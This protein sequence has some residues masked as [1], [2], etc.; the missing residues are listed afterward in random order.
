LFRRDLRV[1]SEI[2]QGWKV[3]EEFRSEEMGWGK[4][5]QVEREL[6]K[7]GGNGSGDEKNRQQKGLSK[8]LGQLR[9]RME[10]LAVARGESEEAIDDGN[11]EDEDEGEEDPMDPLT[12]LKNMGRQLKKEQEQ[13]DGD[14]QKKRKDLE[15]RRADLQRLERV[16]LLYV[17]SA[18]FL[19][20]VDPCTLANSLSLHSVTPSQTYKALSLFCSNSYSL[21]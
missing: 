19:Q 18:K 3:R 16:E 15:E 8:G 1:S 12:V 20:H 11:E 6:L 5:E 4:A 7:D 14:D 21:P 10:E 17:S 2:W 13:L 9:R